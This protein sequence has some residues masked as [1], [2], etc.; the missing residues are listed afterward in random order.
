MRARPR[1]G[2]GGDGA[3]VVGVEAA[4]D[5]AGAA[6]PHVPAGL[7]DAAD[8]A[9]PRR[10][11]AA[12][13]GRGATPGLR[14]RHAGRRAPPRGR[15][16]P[17]DHV[18]AGGAGG[19]PPPDGRGRADGRDPHRVRRGRDSSPS[20]RRC[21]ASRASRA[22]ARATGGRSP[23]APSSSPEAGSCRC[24]AGSRRSAPTR[25][26][27]SRRGAAL[28]P[29]PGS[30]ASTCGPDE[31]HRVSTRLS[32][33]GRPG[34]HE[35]RAVRRRRVDV[36]RRALAAGV[37][38]RAARPAPRGRPHGGG[39]HAARERGLARPRP[40]DADRPGGGDGAGTKRAAPL[41]RPTAD[42][43]RSDCT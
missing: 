33:R 23:P 25:P 43:W 9:R 7:P 19:H 22:C 28:S 27:S 12:L 15:G 37:G 8:R 34:L 10:G 35:L 32:G 40:G 14:A 13:R 4:R 3:D 17:R 36:L 38:S 2:A 31:D 18:P 21:R 42:R 30:S 41:R 39:P 5:P 20:R 29:S 1:P 24:R 16:A 11:R 26:R 6:R